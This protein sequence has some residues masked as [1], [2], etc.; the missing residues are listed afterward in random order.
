MLE[1]E[2]ALKCITSGKC[3]TVYLE[4]DIDH[5]NARTVRSRIDT[6]IYIQRP[7]ELILDL[8]RVNFM[9][10]SGLGL[11]LGR[12]TK[13]VELG[14]LFKVANPSPQIRKILDLAGTERLIK[15]ENIPLREQRMY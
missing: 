11:I 15:I 7:E 2:N 12:Y 9:D 10:S 6:K 1:Y 4:G 5:H 8:S 14:I 13:A 3:L